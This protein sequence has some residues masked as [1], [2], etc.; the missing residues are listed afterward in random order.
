M[1]I[2]FKDNPLKKQEYIIN[3]ASLGKSNKEIAQELGYKDVSNLYTFMRRR[4]MG[5]NA[6]KGLFIVKGEKAE[7]PEAIEEKPSG[8][9][10]SIISM[11]EK[12]MDGREIANSL[13]FGSYQEMADY[14]KSKGYVWDNKKHNYIRVVV[15]VEAEQINKNSEHKEHSSQ[16]DTSNHS[17]TAIQCNCMDKYADILKLLDAKKDRINELL[18]VKEEENCNIPRYTLTGYTAPKS[19]SMISTL[20]RLITEFSRDK[21]ISQK[22]IIEVAVVEFLK[23]Y[24]YVSQVKAVLHV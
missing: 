24:G 11:F 14:M 22:E 6:K 9:V 1:S 15:E 8:K 20:E 3:L 7:E 2:I 17:N 23:K 5:W 16:I 18:K 4:G 10:G 19:L 21:N 13:R 12:K